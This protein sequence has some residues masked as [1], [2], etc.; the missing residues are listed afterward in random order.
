VTP[1]QGRVYS[2]SWWWYPLRKCTV[3]SMLCWVCSELRCWFPSWDGTVALIQGWVCS[4][5]RR[6][7][8]SWDG[9]VALIQ[10][11]VCSELKCLFPT[12]DGTVTIISI[13]PELKSLCP[14]SETSATPLPTR[15]VHCYD[16][17]IPYQTASSWRFQTHCARY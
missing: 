9:T 14:S 2:G 16:A 7:F 10:G 12:Y 3:I 5:L 1:I 13:W 11:P 6:W 15:H 8:P 17:D 4:E